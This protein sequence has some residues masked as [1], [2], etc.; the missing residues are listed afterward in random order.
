MTA[1]S[2]TLWWVDQENRIKKLEASNKLLRD[3][4]DRL[5]DMVEY[6]VSRIDGARIPT[7]EAR[8]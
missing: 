2:E 8:G 5:S 3:E 7:Q 6:L 1:R 4:Y